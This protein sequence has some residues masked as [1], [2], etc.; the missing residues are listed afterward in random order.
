MLPEIAIGAIVAAIIGAMISLVGLVVAKE[1]KVS[2]FRQAWIDSLRAEFASFASNLNVLSDSNVLEFDSPKERFDKLKDNTSKLNE[3]YY[4]VALRLNVTEESS[5]RVR[6][7]MVKLATAVKSPETFSKTDFDREQVEFIAASNLLLKEEWK[8]VKAGERAYRWTG[9][10]AAATII[11]L[12]AAIAV[13]L[14]AN[15]VIYRPSEP[16]AASPNVL[17]GAASAMP[18][19]RPPANKRAGSVTPSRKDQNVRVGPVH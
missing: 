7:S 5:A 2:D 14:S 3:A 4:R 17:P 9:R 10:M 13:V 16:A 12:F 15:L 18:S 1:S 11:V 8:R 19:P 6:A